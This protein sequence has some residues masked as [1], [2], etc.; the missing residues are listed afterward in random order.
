MCVLCPLGVPL[1]PFPL[2]PLYRRS[3][4]R[5]QALQ[6]RLRRNSG[7]HTLVWQIVAMY[8]DG[9][10]GTLTFVKCYLPKQ[11]YFDGMHE[12]TP[13]GLAGMIMQ[14]FAMGL[15]CF[16]FILSSYIV[17]VLPVEALGTSFGYK[18][19][20]RIG[21]S[22]LLMYIMASDLSQKA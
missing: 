3:S 11:H 2:C 10:I 13:H 15:P 18:R 14:K 5:A 16:V 21:T 7:L 19:C 9:A 12:V 8:S 20:L 17:I 6:A 22:F 4:H 1:R